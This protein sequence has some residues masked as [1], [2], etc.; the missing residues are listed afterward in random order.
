M[1]FRSVDD[2][3]VEAQRLYKLG[4]ARYE[5][6]DF[7]AA[8][9]YWTEAYA[10]VP[11]GDPATHRVRTVLVRNLS[12]AHLKA[13]EVDEDQ[14][15]LRTGKMLLGR[16]IK[17]LETYYADEGDAAKELKEAQD[18]LAEIEAKL[19]KIEKEKEDAKAADAANAA[20][21]ANNQGGNNQG[22]NNQVQDPVD[23]G[24]QVDEAGMR[25][26]KTLM[27]VGGVVLGLG[28]GA[29]AG[30]GVGGAAMGSK[31]E[32]DAPEV[33]VELRPDVLDRGRVGN[34]LAYT[35]LVVGGVGI[36]TG[37]VLLAI[38]AKKKKQARQMSLVPTLSPRNAGA[39]FSLEF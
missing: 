23:P 6:F 19:A 10:L 11:A 12:V 38:G 31:A 9:Q 30:L 39:T 8:I 26:G 36:I 16:Y 17:E 33:D 32:S 13:F 37:V 5:L 21:A 24:P 18:Q 25:K 22:G 14:V 2:T 34:T 35:G 3:V 20:N 27:I 15:H 7:T 4:E 1:L 28:V 29:G